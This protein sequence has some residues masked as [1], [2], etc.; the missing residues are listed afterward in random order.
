MESIESFADTYHTSS[1]RT[2][3]SRL[4]YEVAKRLL[5]ITVATVGL[6]LFLPLLP[7]VA[8]A[9]KLDSEGPIFYH[10]KVVGRGGRAFRAFKLRTMCDYAV[11]SAMDEFDINH[12]LREDPR[13]T[14]VGRLLR[15]TSIDEMPQLINVLKGEMSFV[16]P[17]MVSFPELE[18][19]GI[20]QE[21]I[22]S[23][24]PGITGL[25]QV[26]GRSDLSYE[27]RVRPVSYTH[28]TLPTILLV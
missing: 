28:L 9:I 11:I 21:K 22:L 6:A 8:I 27:E 18:K 13:T 12:K 7:V 20:W 5:D 15:K 3:W 10:R 2:I 26:S 4:G 24:K 16:G 17:R 25:W 23:V 19:F 14:G 1:V